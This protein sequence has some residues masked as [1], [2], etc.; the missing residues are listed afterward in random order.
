M[1]NIATKV[2][3][4][5]PRWLVLSLAIPL[6]VLNGWALL[7][8][9]N[10]FGSIVAVLAIAT[11]LA[12]I[13]DYPVQLLQK[14]GLQRIYA[15]LIV[16]FL[17]LGVF[18]ALGLF[19]LPLLIMQFEGLVA[20]I[21]HW[22]ASA[23]QQLDRLQEWAI[24]RRIPIDLS[25]LS[26][27]LEQ[28]LPQE[29][30]N[31]PT[32]LFKVVLETADSVFDI[33]L[34]IALVLYLLL[35]GKGFWNGIL[36]WLPDDLGLEIRKSLRQ[37]FQN[38]FV[39]QVTVALIQGTVL[40]LAFFVL[41]L[42]FF[43]LFGMGIGLLVLIPFFD[44]LGVLIVSLLVGLNNVWLGVTVLVV[45]LMLD[46]IIDNAITPRILGDLVGLNPVWIILSL[47]IGAKVAGFL[48][49][50]VAIP[51]ASTIREIVTDLCPVKPLSADATRAP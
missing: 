20:Q 16:F 28:S 49:I 50:L 47:L 31:L 11:L 21:P 3:E 24:L 37:N 18:V 1:T 14:Q 45:A 26:D 5:L 42:P 48:G 8:L 23:S 29:L 13:L 33:I 39:G 30:Q 25:T 41:R 19:L 17:A 22:S 51:L 9:L 44:F 38:Y 35:H 34:T 10:Y 4:K 46:Q 40:T 27:Q 6:C 32:Q 2:T 12:F 43:L 7:L 36:Q 15:I